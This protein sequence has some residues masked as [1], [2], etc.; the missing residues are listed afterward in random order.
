M[1]SKTTVLICTPDRVAYAAAPVVK[2]CARCGE[3]KPTALYNREAKKR[4]GFCAWCKPCK[5]RDQSRRRID[6][7]QHDHAWRERRRTFAKLTRLVKSGSVVKPMHCPTCAK[8]VVAREMQAQF[9]DGAD[10]RSVK[11]R[12]RAC[13]LA[14]AGASL[15]TVCQWCNEPF[16]VQTHQVRRG[17]GRYCCLRCRNAWMHATAEHVRGVRGDARTDAHR[18][19][20][21]DRF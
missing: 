21:N 14:Q 18:V 12:C 17:A 15:A 2:R 7:L 10:A 16:R 6:L 4:D 11:W 5:S 1:T 20:I 3:D 19:F 8:R 9:A 13:A